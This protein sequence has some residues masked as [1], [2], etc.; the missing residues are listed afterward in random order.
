MEGQPWAQRGALGGRRNG[1]GDPGLSL[2]LSAPRVEF[3]AY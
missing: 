3:K 1:N 2:R